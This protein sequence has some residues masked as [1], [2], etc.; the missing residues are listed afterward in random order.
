M[1][2]SSSQFVYCFYPIL[3]INDLPKINKSNAINV[4]CQQCDTANIKIENEII[5]DC[6]CY[7]CSNC[8]HEDIELLDIPFRK[9][10]NR[11]HLMNEFK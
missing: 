4:S 11:N 1:G 7:K 5:E 6:K 8:I 9:E 3:Y 2:G 10:N